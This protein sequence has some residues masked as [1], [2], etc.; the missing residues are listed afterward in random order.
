MNEARSL[1]K[2]VNS[3]LQVQQ[4]SW[5]EIDAEDHSLIK[6]Q[7]LAI[8]STICSFF[9]KSEKASAISECDPFVSDCD[10]GSSDSETDSLPTEMSAAKACSSQKWPCTLCKPA[11]FVAKHSRH[12]TSIHSNDKEVSQILAHKNSEMK[13]LL[14]KRLQFRMNY[15]YHKRNNLDPAHPSN[16]VQ[17]YTRKDG[18]SRNTVR[19]IC[20]QCLRPV[21]K[22][23]L[24]PHLEKYCN[25]TK[26][27]T[28]EASSSDEPKYEDDTPVRA[29]QV[30]GKSA[31]M[32][33][34]LDDDLKAFLSNMRGDIVVGV[35]ENDPVLME[36][37]SYQSER[38]AGSRTE[39]TGRQNVR[40]VVNFLLH[41]RT[42]SDNIVTGSDLVDPTKYKSVA[43][44]L[45]SW[46]GTGA[47]GKPRHPS[48]SKR[49]G[50]LL[51][52]LSKS[53]IDYAIGNELVDL[54]GSV[55]LW[56]DLHK[57][58]H[59]LV[60][61]NTREQLKLRTLN[62]Q[63]FFPFFEDIEKLNK[64][65]DNKME[66]W[67]YQETEEA[68]LKICSAV[69]AKIILFNRKRQGEA[70]KILVTDFERS[71]QKNQSKGDPHVL[72]SMDRVSRFLQKSMFMLEFVAKGGGRGA[73][74]LT[75]VM[76]SR[77]KDIVRMRPAVVLSKS[78]YF[79][80]RPGRCSS[81]IQGHTVLTAEAKEAQ[82]KSPELFKS[83]ALRKHMATMAQTCHLTGNDKALL[84]SY[85]NHTQLVHSTYYEKQLTDVAKGTVAQILFR[86][87]TGEFDGRT[88]T[89][90]DL[91]GEFE[92][93]IDS[94]QGEIY[95][96]N[97]SFSVRC[98]ADSFS[99]GFQRSSFH[100][101][102]RVRI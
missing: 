43:K 92:L 39:Q 95:G 15:D 93:P 73:V 8:A 102:V 89:E 64:H 17:A 94:D 91:N 55:L 72:D 45:S 69:L 34:K 59:A 4:K 36:F 88:V 76:L 53:A 100:G 22:T 10:A 19:T 30:L 67:V 11:V 13:G 97:S 101:W 78:V 58:R 20:H 1:R 65:L 80:A 98:S 49:V 12:L 62:S 23:N 3:F 24:V 86:M 61:K 26:I 54:R 77:M 33:D 71:L 60:S 57:R 99:F 31:R 42:N 18:S 38:Y 75:D 85:M 87:N 47:D 25:E 21:A 96:K 82:V 79:F 84:V 68:Y 2:S 6:V 37:V 52:E 29:H 50:E 27:K 40:H 83:T 90:Q 14:F 44:C 51:S 7:C 74:L 81:H 32:P 35:V 63:T 56:Q 48:K 46:A 5:A 70:S 16:V 66:T 28:L 9:E 41:C